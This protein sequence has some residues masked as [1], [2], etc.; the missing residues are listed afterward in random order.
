MGSANPS[1][2]KTSLSLPL[3]AVD[4]LDSG[5]SLSD[6]SDDE[7]DEDTEE[8]ELDLENPILWENIEGETWDSIFF[9]L[10]SLF[11]C[12]LSLLCINGIGM[13]LNVFF[14]KKRSYMVES[15]QFRYVVIRCKQTRN[16]TVLT[17]QEL[18]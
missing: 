2:F 9:T 17:E 8:E 6:L 18:G 3:E 16:Y 11:G 5:G 4:L 1:S 12:W 7:D 13:V 14:H 10:W 15:N